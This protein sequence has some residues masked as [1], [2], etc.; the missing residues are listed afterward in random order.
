MGS[1]NPFEARAGWWAPALGCALTLMVVVAGWRGEPQYL[2]PGGALLAAAVR[3]EGQNLAA[4]LAPEWHSD[5]NSLPPANLE[6]T[7]GLLSP[8]SKG[9][10]RETHT[11][12]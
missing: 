7:N 8:S 4:F 5:Q 12:R 10:I 1:A 3:G 9:L 2:H 11:N 6:S